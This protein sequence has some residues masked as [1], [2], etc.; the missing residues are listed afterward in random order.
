MSIAMERFGSSEKE[1]EL[2][3]SSIVPGPNFPYRLQCR[4]CGFEPIEVFALPASCPKCG[5]HSWERFASVRSLLINCDRSVKRGPACDQP[6]PVQ[7]RPE[8]M[9]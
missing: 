8:P 4:A 7:V 3:P 1:S 9:P 5:G 2:T 6:S